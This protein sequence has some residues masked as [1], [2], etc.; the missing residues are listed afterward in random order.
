MQFICVSIFSNIP[1]ELMMLFALFLF[2]IANIVNVD[3][4]EVPIDQINGLNYLYISTGGVN[5]VW[6]NSSSAGI[7]WD[8]NTTFNSSSNPCMDHWQGINCTENCVSSTS[9]PCYI[10]S[11]YLYDNNMTGTIPSEIAF[12]ST[13]SYL[14]LTYNNLAGSLPTSIGQLTDLTA[15]HLNSNELSGHILSL[16]LNLEKLQSVELFLNHFSGTI[17]ADLGVTLSNLEIFDIVKNDFSGTIPAAIGTWKHLEVMDLY[18]NSLSGTVPSEITQLTGLRFLELGDNLLTSSVPSGL[19]NLILLRYIAWGLNA[20]TGTMPSEIGLMTNLTFIGVSYNSMEGTLPSTLVDLV[21]MRFFSCRYNYFTSPQG[22]DDTLMSIAKLPLLDA[23]LINRN[24]FSGNFKDVAFATSLKLLRLSDNHFTGPYLINNLCHLHDIVEVSISNNEFSGS[25]PSCVG[26]WSSVRTLDMG[27]NNFVGTIPTVFQQFSQMVRLVLESNKFSGDLTNVFAEN[28][29]IQTIL[30]S[31]NSFTG[32][33][34]INAFASNSVTTFIAS[35]NCFDGSLSESICNAVNLQTLALS[36]LTAGSACDNSGWLGLGSYAKSVG[37]SIPKC[38]FEMTELQQ[39]YLSGNGIESQLSP[40]AVASPLRNISL[41]YNRLSGEIPSSIQTRGTLQ[42]LDLSFNRLLGT[43]EQ[44]NNYSMSGTETIVDPASGTELFVDADIDLVLA[45]NHLS[46]SIP[47][48]FSDS[49]GPMDI[50][51]GNM[52]ECRSLSSLP[53]SDSKA[54]HY[55]CGSD[56]LDVCMYIF[57]GVFVFVCGSSIYYYQTHMYPTQYPHSVSSPNDESSTLR[58]LYK[59]LFIPPAM[60]NKPD[61]D[62]AAKLVDYANL[63]LF[64]FRWM[65]LFIAFITVLTIVP[66]SV[67]KMDTS[68][69]SE[70]TYQ[71]GWVISMAFLNGVVPGTFI[72]VLWCGLI[73]F[74][75]LYEHRYINRKRIKTT[76]RSLPTLSRTNSKIIGSGGSRKISKWEV[77]AK[78]CAIVSIN[79]V[80]SLC[81][82]GMYVYIVITQSFSIQILAVIFVSMF[83]MLWPPLVIIPWLNTVASKFLL[84]M[85]VMISNVIVIPLLAAMAVEPACFSSLLMPPPPIST[86]FG[87]RVCQTF[88]ADLTCLS[89]AD[90]E[91]TISFEAPH[92]YNNQCFSAILTTYAPSYVISFGVVGVVLPFI[93]MCVCSY[94]ATCVMERNEEKVGRMH[95]LKAHGFKLMSR[96]LPLESVDDMMK[97]SKRNNS[98]QRKSCSS[99]SKTYMNIYYSRY[100]SMNCIM[101]LTMLLT[102]GIVYPPLSC[103]LVTNVF[104]STLAFQ[105]SIYYH[106]LQIAKLDVDCRAAWHICLYN[107]ISILHKIMFGSRLV[108]LLFSSLFAAFVLYDTVSLDSRSIAWLLIGLVIG[109][110]YIAIHICRK[111]DHLIKYHDPSSDERDGDEN[112]EGVELKATA[113]FVNNNRGSQN[114]IEKKQGALDNDANHVCVEN[115]ML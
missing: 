6:S 15:L 59:L 33:V 108:I 22:T 106:S 9:S 72:T 37:G 102:F 14:S 79:L 80:I 7:S 78:Q 51:D 77:L 23:F 89:F 93:Q 65:C 17:P 112:Y 8:F 84:A 57:L 109:S 82:N 26:N 56:V 85:I 62:P 94:F 18:D 30:L 31:D 113:V 25:I 36:G 42:L 19:S 16:L 41:S 45:E 114:K 90:A 92:I 52:F 111:Y 91:T 43:I 29:K 10:T 71:Y 67:L 103:V 88:Y 46:G 13:L 44:M 21:E 104:M 35:K 73:L 2:H 48:V 83:K 24:F 34:P 3:C 53:E 39:L 27:S 38:L 54:N 20:I 12:I 76:F 105:L 75:L 32:S 107:E 49:S 96:L 50:L 101:L 58:T 110:T 60:K 100:V 97:Q 64:Q 55:A 87:Y 11:I 74:V 95:R 61:N 1:I 47:S 63:I 99:G 5:W 40:L 4:G 66:I 68:K 70:Q 98:S 81:V 115:P 28:H 69:Y 86:T